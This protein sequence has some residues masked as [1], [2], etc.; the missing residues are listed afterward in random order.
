MDENNQDLQKESQKD[1]IYREFEIPQKENNNPNNNQKSDVKQGIIRQQ[2][3]FQKKANQKKSS[4][5]NDNTNNKIQNNEED[6]SNSDDNL[7]HPK[8]LLSDYFDEGKDEIRKYFIEKIEQ[9]NKIVKDKKEER[10]L[11]DKIEKDN[12]QTYLGVVKNL[13][14]TFRM[15]VEEEKTQKGP[16]LVSKFER[17]KRPILADNNL[18][19]NENSKNRSN[20][21]KKEIK[22]KY[23]FPMDRKPVNMKMSRKKLNYSES[24]K[25]TERE[26]KIINNPIMNNRYYK[27][28]SENNLEEKEPYFN[29]IKKMKII[30][31]R[32]SQQPFLCKMK[33][34]S[35]NEKGIKYNTNIKKKYQSNEKIYTINNSCRKISLNQSSTKTDSHIRK[36]SFGVSQEE[37]KVNQNIQNRR[38]SINNNQNNLSNNQI[39]ISS[40]NIN[41][42][43]YQRI[44]IN[45]RNQKQYNIERN[46]PFIKFNNI[47][48][49]EDKININNNIFYKEKCPF[50]LVNK[51]K[52]QTFQ[53]GGEFNNLQTKY[54]IVSKK[55][56]KQGISSSNK[57]TIA[58]TNL[59]Q[60]IN[61]NSSD[62]Y[63][64]VNSKFKTLESSFY[65]LNSH[66]NLLNTINKRVSVAFSNKNKF[67]SPYLL[68]HKNMIR[69]PKNQIKQKFLNKSQNNYDTK[70]NCNDISEGINSY[71]YRNTE[72]DHI[73]RNPIKNRDEYLKFNSS[74]DS[75]KRYHNSSEYNF[76]QDNPKNKACLTERINININKNNK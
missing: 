55:D 53:R 27:Q 33:N 38:S 40:N 30:N 61:L 76:R 4:S 42:K 52:T 14:K 15:S 6:G 12:K 34:L 47:K 1:L 69:F 65:N 64:N 45:P 49:P 36:I 60:E 11:Y 73:I 41:K 70:K 71:K 46:L 23:E 13:G 16:T 5:R 21:E 43:R 50:T 58:N 17:S 59:S 25:L 3:N 9:G 66:N 22:I 32:N 31:N 63:S 48:Y 51:V 10:V 37:R 39:S 74:I 57:I 19:S 62:I 7:D 24:V 35:N 2:K 67:K 18:S 44:N 68:N 29:K 56:K 8:P 20:I 75:N 26:I 54:V 28:N 72:S